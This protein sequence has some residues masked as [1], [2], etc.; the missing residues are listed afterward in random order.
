[1]VNSKFG[2]ILTAVGGHIA[3]IVGDDHDGA[4]MYAESDGG[5]Y[6]ASIFKDAGEAVVYFDPDDALFA[7]LERLWHAAEHDK[8]WEIL[9]YEI[10]GET[11]DAR[12][13]FPEELDPEESIDDRRQR[14][15][16][17]RYGDKPV[18]YPPMDEF[19]HEL[20]EADLPDD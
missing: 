13:G 19:F 4:Y 16:Q 9:H 14:A 18:I 15:L 10:K 5:S 1:M 2:E 7:E 11:F 6:G 20:G 17:E 12:F 3:A 8:K